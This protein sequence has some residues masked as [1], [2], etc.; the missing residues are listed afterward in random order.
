MRLKRFEVEDIEK[1]EGIEED[2]V[3]EVEL[4]NKRYVRAPFNHC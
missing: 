4:E 2:D 3:E 1:V